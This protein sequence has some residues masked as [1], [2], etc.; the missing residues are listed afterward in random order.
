M[1]TPTSCPSSSEQKQSKTLSAAS[2]L[3][4]KTNKSKIKQEASAGFG[5]YE[6]YKYY[7]IYFVY[8][9]IFASYL[10]WKN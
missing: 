5:L 6:T 8:L 4:L 7:L 1:E 10:H 9:S 3:T 2:E